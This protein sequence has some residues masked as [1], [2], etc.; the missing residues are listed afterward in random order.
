MIRRALFALVALA[1]LAAAG[2]GGVRAGEPALGAT[3]EAIVY[4]NEDPAVSILNRSNV[5]GLFSVSTEGFGWSVSDQPFVLEPD[6][7]RDVPLVGIGDAEGSLLVHV[8]AAE[9]PPP[10]VQRGEIVLEVRLLPERPFDWRALLIGG[11]LFVLVVGVTAAT[12]VRRLRSIPH[13]GVSR[14]SPRR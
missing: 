13:G 8:V 1:A 5:P 14:F 12:V 10:G 2:A 7:Q 4:A 3:V 6:E 11:S 9:T